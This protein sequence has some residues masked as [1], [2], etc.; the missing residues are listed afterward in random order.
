[1]GGKGG[2]EPTI[3]PTSTLTDSQRAVLDKL[4]GLIEGQ[5]GVGVAPYK[6]QMTSGPSDIQ[7]SQFDLVKQILGGTATGQQQTTDALSSV[8]KPWNS[9]DATSWWE[10]S[11]KDPTLQS[12]NEDILPGISEKFAAYD[13]FGGGGSRKSLLD[14]GVKLETGMQKNLADALLQDKQTSNQQM[15]SA[16][17]LNIEDLMGRA[18]LGGTAG[19]TQRGITNDQLSEGYQKWLQKQPYANPWLSYLGSSLGTQAFENIVTPGT[20]E[21]IGGILGGAG[22]L[23]K[24]VGSL[25]PCCFIFIEAH[26]GYLHPIVRRYRD[27]HMTERN[28]RG[29]YRLA[30]KLVPWMRRSKAVHKAVEWLMVKPMTN[31]GKY[32]YGEG[33]IGAVFA[34]IAAF[35][36]GVFNLLGF[37]KF[38]RSNGEVI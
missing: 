3:T 9:G 26:G 1:M 19:A 30:E 11:I 28:R 29:Y 20:S 38:R 37:G 17:G 5:I 15:L 34:P 18:N 6:G 31:Y 25:K 4:S 8:I 35:W 36:L 10:K 13:A 21:S 23:L 32:F 22:G 12:W 2:S 33:R 7:G 16:A 27:E 24:G 14:A